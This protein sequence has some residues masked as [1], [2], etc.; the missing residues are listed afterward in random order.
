MKRIILLTSFMMLSTLGAQTLTLNKCINKALNTHPDI[1]RFMLQVKHS[2]YGV[3]AARADYL[4]QVSFNAEY[5]PAKTYALP[6]NGIFHT[7]DSDGWQAEVTVRQKIWDF[8]KTL[9]NIEAQEV[10]EEIANLSLRDAKA[11]LAYKVKLQYELMLVQK[12]AIQVRQKDLNAKEELYKQAQALVKRGMK[13]KADSTRFLSSVYAAKDNLAIARSGFEKA[14]TTLSLYINETITNNVKLEDSISKSNWHFKSKAHILQ[15][16]PALNSLKKNINKNELLYK[17]AKASHY[18]SIDA[19]VSY[20][21]QDTLNEYD[22]TLVGITLN[23]PLYSGGRISALEEQ[24]M[25]SKQ[26]AESEYHSKKLALTE[27]FE[28]LLID[29]KRYKQTI[30]AKK[31]QL[32]AARQTQKVLE[33]RYK[34]GLSIY[35]EVLDAYAL[36]LDAQLGLLQAKYERSSTIHR[37]EYLQGK[38]LSS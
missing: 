18:G 23:I 19:V 37:L 7:I 16:S 2:K 13:T 31:V 10:Q 4:P 28:R 1:K 22:S 36:T 9:S 30:K 17:S 20:T 12:K 32:K 29:L 15:N 25:I 24:A 5:D 33:A 11:L 27:E 6:L 3:D 14:K 34:E 21:R 26:S 38:I 35:I 8:S